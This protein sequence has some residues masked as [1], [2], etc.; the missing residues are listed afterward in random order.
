MLTATGE[1]L[2]PGRATLIN[3]TGNAPEGVRIQV[4]QRRQARFV[5][6][7]GS[8]KARGAWFDLP[9][10]GEIHLG[11]R[12]LIGIGYFQFTSTP[13]GPVGYLPSVY[14]DPQWNSVPALLTITAD[15]TELAALGLT[16]EEQPGLPM[17]LCQSLARSAGI[18]ISGGG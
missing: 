9:T 12:N 5:T 8:T 14:F 13:G 18:D 7:N 10:S 17:K 1:Q 3:V 6:W 16:A 2:H 15:P 4:N 11:M